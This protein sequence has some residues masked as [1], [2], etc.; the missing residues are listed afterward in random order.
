MS[1]MPRNLDFISAYC[2]HNLEWSLGCLQDAD[3]FLYLQARP[4]SKHPGVRKKALD[5]SGI[6]AESKPPSKFSSEK[7]QNWVI[8]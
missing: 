1:H 5:L 3:I 8:Y 2:S 4:M 7:N 6:D